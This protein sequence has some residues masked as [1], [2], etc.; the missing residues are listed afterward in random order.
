MSG[1][2]AIE[3]FPSASFGEYW[4]LFQPDSGDRHF[5]VTAQGASV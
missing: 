2:V 5:V 4:R 3:A 1:A